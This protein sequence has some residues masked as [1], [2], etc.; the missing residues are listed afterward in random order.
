MEWLADLDQI[1]QTLSSGARSTQAAADLAGR[2]KGLLST[3]KDAGDPQL[4][5]LVV[6]LLNEVAD[7]KLANAD[8]KLKLVELQEAVLAAQKAEARAQKYALAETSVGHFVR[9]YQRTEGDPT[10]DHDACP[11]CFERGEIHPLHR[12]GRYGRCVA[13]S[14]LFAYDPAPKPKPRQTRRSS[15]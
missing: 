15:F 4:A 13:C 3:P 1:F 6:D 12:Q 7:A 9:R 5:G 10:P 14:G 11:K 2:I 8:L